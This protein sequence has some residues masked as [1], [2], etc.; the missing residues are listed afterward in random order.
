MLP[1]RLRATPGSEPVNR[2][3]KNGYLIGLAVAVIVVLATLVFGI[4]PLFAPSTTGD[5]TATTTSTA[6]DIAASSILASAVQRA[7]AGYAETTSKPLNITEPGFENGGD[8]VFATQEGTLANMTI[9]VFGTPSSAQA[10]MSSVAAN[11]KSLTGYS[12]I[13]SVLA[14]YQRYG[15]CYGFGQDNPFGAG[16]VATGICTKGN[17]Y[18]QVHLSAASTLSSVEGDVSSLVGAAYQGLG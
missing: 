7:P 5:G 9:L 1:S 15:A 18:I 8:A 17:V 12:D 16:A 11:A 2:F 4:E 10:Y 14:S 6:Y 13:S 3:P